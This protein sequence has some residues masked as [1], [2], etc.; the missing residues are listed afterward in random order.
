MKQVFTVF[1]LAAILFSNESKAQEFFPRN[2]IDTNANKARVLKWNIEADSLILHTISTPVLSNDS[3]VNDLISLM[4]MTVR[5][6]SSMGVGI[7]APQIGVN[8]RLVLVQRFDKEN[9]PFEAYINPTIIKRSELKAIRAEGCLSIDDCRAEVERSY[10]ILISYFT[11]DGD[12]EMEM[13]E[14]FV[15]RIFQHEIDHLDGI[16]FTQRT[17]KQ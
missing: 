5:D 11:V 12:Y 13:V 10:A 17:V 2:Y 8:K 1:L 16:L 14:D 9:E 15:A 7:A 6:S 4:Y 3:T